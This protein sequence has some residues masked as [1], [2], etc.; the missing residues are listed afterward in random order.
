MTLD[1]ALRAVRSKERAQ[2]V[3]AMSAWQ[4]PGSLLDDLH[5]AL[6]A[7]PAESVGNFYFEKSDTRV[8]VGRTD[9][10]LADGDD[11]YGIPALRGPLQLG[12]WRLEKGRLCFYFWGSDCRAYQADSVEAALLVVA[13]LM[14]QQRD[15][16]AA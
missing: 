1:E 6:C 10:F 7:A 5:L 11:T 14:L 15:T 2:T 16:E 3:A 8:V 12:S 13:D 9:A 4:K